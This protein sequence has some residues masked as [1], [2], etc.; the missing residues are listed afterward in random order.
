MLADY[1]KMHDKSQ[2]ELCNI[3]QQTLLYLIRF[4]DENDSRIIQLQSK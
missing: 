3:L 4:Q 1:F 2:A